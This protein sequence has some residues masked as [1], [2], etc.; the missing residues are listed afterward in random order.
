MFYVLRILYEYCTNI[1]RILYEYFTGFFLHPKSTNILRI[2]YVLRIFYEYCTNILRIFYGFLPSPQI[3]EYST[4]ILF[5]VI[6]V[7][8]GTVHGVHIIQLSFFAKSLLGL[9]R[10]ELLKRRKSLGKKR[11]KNGAPL[12]SKVFFLFQILRRMGKHKSLSSPH[13]HAFSH[14]S[15]VNTTQWHSQSSAS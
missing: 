3:H 12:T 13:L 14:T 6:V 8:H 1:V 4:N 11:K 7:R 9:F 2:F 15:W 5:A 10:I